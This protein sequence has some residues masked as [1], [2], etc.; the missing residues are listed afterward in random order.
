MKKA[1][2]L[3]ATAITATAGLATAPAS[4]ATGPAAPA[5]AARSHGFVPRPAEPRT[6]GGCSPI[7]NGAKVCGHIS[8][9]DNYISSLSI[10]A[11][12]YGTGQWVHGEV[13]SPAGEHSN[14]SN[15][16]R[17]GGNCIPAKHIPF[18][19]CGYFGNWK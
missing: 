16:F 17:S 18:H 14:T 15:Y 5:A 2:I 6:T 10:G 3:A 8:G 4:A 7:G 11:C 9:Y 1:Q 13:L 19:Y 12:V